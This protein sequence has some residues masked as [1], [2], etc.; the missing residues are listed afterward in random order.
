MKLDHP[1]STRPL[2]DKA[3]QNELLTSG[4]CGRCA[5]RVPR[6]AIIQAARCSHCDSTLSFDGFDALD[7]LQTRQ[8]RW[9]LFGYGLVAAASFAAGAVPLLQLVVQLL[10]LYILHVIV[11]RHSLA[12]LPA[13]RR[14]L[15]R[16]SIKLLGAAIATLALLINV[17]IAPLVGISALILGAIGPLLTAAY[18]EG[19]LIIV[20]RRL[21]WEAR[22]QAIKT[23]EWALPVGLLVAL[24]VAVGGTVAMVVGAL[25]VLSSAELPAVSE[26]SRSLLEI[27]P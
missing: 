19:G 7:D 22:G 16:L 26:I 21:R 25:H 12:W 10:A 4:R 20:R 18:V 5:E 1:Y 14:I 6:A 27:A 9:R 11:L 8:L 23:G 2:D 17:A 3:H 13:G 24:V 15:A